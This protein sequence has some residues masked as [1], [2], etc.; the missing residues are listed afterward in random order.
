MQDEAKTKEQLISELQQMHQQIAELNK[1]EA[2]RSGLDRKLSFFEIVAEQSVDSIVCTDAEFRI[3][4]INSAAEKLFGWSLDELKGKTPDIFNAEPSTDEIQQQ[5]Y[6]TV[7]SGGTYLGE[8][9]NVR[10]DGSTFY[11][12]FK[13]AP[14]FDENDE[15]LGYMGLQRDITS[16]KQAEEA[17]K[18]AE[19]A[20]RESQSKYRDLVE[21][22]SDVIYAADGNGIV[23]YVSPALES[24][25]GYKPSD[26]IGRNLTELIGGIVHQEQSTMDNLQRLSSGSH[27]DSERRIVT[28][29]GEVRWIRASNRPVL[30][31][32][33]VIGVQGIISDIT[34]LKLAQQQIIQQERLRAI[35]LGR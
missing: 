18:Q 13:V 33:K 3:T 7:S 11:C 22:M 1:L 6:M 31:G 20:L 17:R 35:F 25:I 30:E 4:Y 5:I 10:K 19:E 9:L 8:A 2:E 28:A 23:T 21:N 15:V 26:I 24:L 32:D 16:Y 14:F 12:Q 34:Q 27:S 29:S